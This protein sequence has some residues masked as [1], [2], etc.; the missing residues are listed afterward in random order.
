M[1]MVF[2]QLHEH[3]HELL[4][5]VAT[6]GAAAGDWICYNKLNEMGFWRCNLQE[7]FE[8]ICLKMMILYISNIIDNDVY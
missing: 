6:C 5:V 3:E 8:F 1:L 2:V 7:Y 4:L